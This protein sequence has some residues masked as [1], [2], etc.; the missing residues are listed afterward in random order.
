MMMTKDGGWLCDV[1][2]QIGTRKCSLFWS[3]ETL[4]SAG[5]D[6]LSDPSG[7][8][9]EYGSVGSYV[10]YQVPSDRTIVGYADSRAMLAD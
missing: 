9:N 1:T 2:D 6:P 5:V 10:Q 4:K 8:Y 3:A 7:D